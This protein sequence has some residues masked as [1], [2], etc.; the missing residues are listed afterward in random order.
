MNSPRFYKKKC[1]D[2]K[3]NPEIIDLEISLRA[4]ARGFES[5]PLRHFLA[6]FKLL[7]GF[8]V[9]TLDSIF[10]LFYNILEHTF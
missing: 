3:E 8:F 9:S 5:H 7:R 1:E 4:T 10:E 2:I 6:E